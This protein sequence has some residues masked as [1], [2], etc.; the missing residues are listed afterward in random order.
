MHGHVFIVAFW[1]MA[2]AELV[3]RGMPSSKDWK[4]IMKRVVCG[5]P[6][7]TKAAAERGLRA[8][9]NWGWIAARIEPRSDGEYFVVT[10]VPLVKRL[11]QDRKPYVS[12]PGVLTRRYRWA[13]KL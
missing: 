8:A 5:K 12:A 2:L 13:S 10:G 9:I 1:V 7:S 6:H 11:L 4:T 3:S